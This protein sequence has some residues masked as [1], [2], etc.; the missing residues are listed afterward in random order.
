M[1]MLDPRTVQHHNCMPEIGWRKHP[2]VTASPGQNGMVHCEFTPQWTLCMWKPS[3]MSQVR[4]STVEK[5]QS[6]VTTEQAVL[7]AARAVTVR[8]QP[9]GPFRS[10]SAHRAA[11]ARSKKAPD[12][13]R[14]QH[15]ICCCQQSKHMWSGQ[16][17][18]A[19]SDQPSH[20]DAHTQR[21]HPK[22]QSSHTETVA[23]HQLW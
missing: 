23:C 4:S 2:F 16:P 8:H 21:L 1:S 9:N 12:D 11:N 10:K 20:V 7:W 14:L 17:N 13:Q 6:T 15:T 3:E 19:H 5:T 22:G 18:A